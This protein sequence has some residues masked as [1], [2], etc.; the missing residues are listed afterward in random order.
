VPNQTPG[1][2]AKDA[3]LNSQAA[4]HNLQTTH[5]ELFHPNAGGG[6]SLN[7]DILNFEG[8]KYYK[9]NKMPALGMG[10][11]PL[12]AGIMGVASQLA[13]REA[14]GEDITNPA[15]ETAITNGQDF[16]GA[17][18]AVNS[19]AGG[20]IGNQARAVNNLT[21]H[22]KIME[23]LVNDL[24]NGTFQPGNKVATAW[25]RTFGSPAPTNIQ[26]AA[27]IIGP[28]MAKALSQNSGA[29]TGPER[30]ELS[31]TVG[32]LSNAPE[33]SLQAIHTW[34]DMLGRQMLDLAFQ[35]HGATG[36]S[37]FVR[38][39]VQPDV[40]GYL[41][42]GSEG[43]PPAAA[44]AGGGPAPLSQSVPTPGGASS[45]PSPAGGSSGAAAAQL[46]PQAAAQLK[47]G[48]HTTFGNGQ[49]WTLQ[50]GK[51]VRVQ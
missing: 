20:P 21:G 15:Y 50:N 44:S 29:G 43:G 6:A 33:Q 13:Q 26:A 51:P 22:L 38:R 12:R 27:E 49:I 45:A 3:N 10:N 32:N 19:A 35:Y 25:Q 36:R 46:P 7:P 41:N 47:E 5:P 40:A 16:L 34:R 9:T 24:S 14:N 4:L 42:I 28:E 37:D 1:E 11:A 2:V 48:M 31:H 8:Y 30:E 23:D 39:Y 17:Q 18:K